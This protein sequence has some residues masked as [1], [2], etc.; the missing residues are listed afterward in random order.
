MLIAIWLWLANKIHISMLGKKKEKN[1]STLRPLQLVQLVYKPHG[2]FY[3]LQNHEACM[4]ALLKI[5]GPIY[6]LVR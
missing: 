6:N 4:F 2:Q 1:H 5:I 3:T